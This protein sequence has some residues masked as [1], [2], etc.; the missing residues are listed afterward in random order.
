MET[1]FNSDLVLQGQQ[2]HIQSE[3]WGITNPFLVSR[4]YSNGALLHSV[5]T[6]YTEVLGYELLLSRQDLGVAVREALQSQHQKVLDLL[7]GGQLR[8]R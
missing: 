4:V 5:K 7:R 2:I 1:G 3:D 8:I 6:P